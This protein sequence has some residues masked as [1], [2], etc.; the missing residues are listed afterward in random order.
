MQSA[1]TFTKSMHGEVPRTFWAMQGFI[2]GHIC[3][4]AC[5]VI[6]RSSALRA[7][8]TTVRDELAVGWWAPAAHLAHLPV[9][10]HHLPRSVPSSLSYSCPGGLRPPPSPRPATPITLHSRC[11]PSTS[12]AGPLQAAAGACVAG[13][14]RAG[15][16]FATPSAVLCLVANHVPSPPPRLPMYSRPAISLIALRPYVASL[17]SCCSISCFASAVSCILAH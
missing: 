17:S 12:L 5:T 7:Q 9:L 6:G 3:W 10:P 8:S 16:P 15:L 14:G 4:A 13:S 2:R 11:P 1:F